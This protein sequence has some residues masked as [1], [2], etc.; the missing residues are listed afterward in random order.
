MDEYLLVNDLICAEVQQ[1]KTD[2]T[3]NLQMRSLKYGKL[4]N[5]LLVIV[6]QELVKQLK[7]HMTT[8]PTGVDL[9]FGHNGM[10]W[11]TYTKTKLQRDH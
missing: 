7:T 8:L 11:I 4:V 3:F 2:G 6:Q 10:I 5:G 9:K 1:T